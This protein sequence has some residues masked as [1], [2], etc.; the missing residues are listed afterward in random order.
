MKYRLP[1]LGGTYRNK[2]TIKLKTKGQG[3][4]KHKETL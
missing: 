3:R 2:G 1:S 4:Q